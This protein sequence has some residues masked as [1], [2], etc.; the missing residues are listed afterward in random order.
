M[1][2]YKI[3]SFFSFFIKGIFSLIAYFAFI[4]SSS[5]SKEAPNG[6][7]SLDHLSP[8]PVSVHSIKYIICY[9]EFQNYEVTYVSEL[10]RSYNLCLILNI[11]F[12]E[13]NT[14][15]FFLEILS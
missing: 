1:F 5:S 2:N 11:S 10:Y 14:D 7:N 4:N 12:V 9:S 15:S 3:N 8:C 6:S 13:I